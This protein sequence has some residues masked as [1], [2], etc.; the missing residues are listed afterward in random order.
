MKVFIE[1]A[2]SFGTSG[3]YTHELHWCV[4]VCCMESICE[5][6]LCDWIFWLRV[7]Q[8]ISGHDNNM[9]MCHIPEGNGGSTPSK[10]EPLEMWWHSCEVAYWKRLD[11][12]HKCR[13]GWPFLS[14]AEVVRNCQT[15]KDLWIANEYQVSLSLQ[16]QTSD[17]RLGTP[18]LAIFNAHLF[19]SFSAL[20]LIVSLW[21]DVFL[22]L[23]FISFYGVFRLLIVYQY[24]HCVISI[25]KCSYGVW[26][27]TGGNRIA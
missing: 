14:R 16:S 27:K 15:T 26:D 2:L 21:T 22:Q 19:L 24:Q 12:I 6:Q 25:R 1:W 18:R 4:T 7:L 20:I 10:R 9:A 3:H 8:L 17:F 11:S 5:V 13:A 23:F